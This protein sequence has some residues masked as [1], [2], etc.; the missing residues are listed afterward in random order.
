MAQRRE[1]C[2]P[3]LTGDANETRQKLG[4]TP[5]EVVNAR[6]M[7]E[8]PRSRGGTVNMRGVRRIS[9]DLRT[10]L[11]TGNLAAGSSLKLLLLYPRLPRHTK[12]TKGEA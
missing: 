9:A 3:L 7:E 6:K 12:V 5:C 2:Y 8:C 11:Q 10:H 1:I 4:F